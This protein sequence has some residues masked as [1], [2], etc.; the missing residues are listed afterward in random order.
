MNTIFRVGLELTSQWLEHKIKLKF[1][2]YMYIHLTPIT[3]KG[4]V[5]SWIPYTPVTQC[6]KQDHNVRIYIHRANFSDVIAIIASFEQHF[7]SANKPLKI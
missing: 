6:R 4:I 1:S 3:I 5:L 7:V 2:V